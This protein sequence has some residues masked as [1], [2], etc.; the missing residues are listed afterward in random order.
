MPYVLGHRG[1]PLPE[2]MSHRSWIGSGWTRHVSPFILAGGHQS[3]DHRQTM[4]LMALW[5]RG[6]S[7]V[8]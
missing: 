1:K 7:I 6:I 5:R 2:T 3:L 8:W 4:D